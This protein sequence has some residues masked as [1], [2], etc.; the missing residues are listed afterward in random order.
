MKGFIIMTKNMKRLLS[1]LICVAMLL[2]F[3]L[4]SFALAEGNSHP[5]NEKFI[6]FLN[7]QTNTPGVTNEDE[8]WAAAERAKDEFEGLVYGLVDSHYDIAPIFKCKMIGDEY[9]VDELNFSFFYFCSDDYC[10]E[11]PIVTNYRMGLLEVTPDFYGQLDVSETLI[12]KIN[13]QFATEGHI[14]HISSVNANDCLSLEKVSFNNQPYC[15]EFTA[16]NCPQ[17]KYATLTGGVFKNIALQL[18]GSESPLDISAI[19]DGAVGFDGKYTV[20]NYTLYAYGEEEEFVGWFMAGQCISTEMEFLYDGD[21]TLYACF[22]GDVN[23]DGNITLS[24]AALIMRSAMNLSPLANI[25]SGDVDADG[26]I[27]VSDALF[28]MRIA[29]GL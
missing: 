28:T 15:T 2:G 12:S 20:A 7:Q 27:T 6:A 16:L 19:G 3:T 14:T 21:G 25:G 8:I 23:G 24:D 18:V 10:P 1:M 17:L 26:I 29:M 5:S 11:D 13:G 9:Y 22:A 4:G